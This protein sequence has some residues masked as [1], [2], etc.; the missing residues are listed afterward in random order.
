M[1]LAEIGIKSRIFCR[2]GDIRI[3]GEKVIDPIS[4]S[5]DGFRHSIDKKEIFSF[6]V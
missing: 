2:K 3:M 4:Q 6:S 1:K 5:L